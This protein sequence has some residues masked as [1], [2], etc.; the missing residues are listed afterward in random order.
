[1]AAKTSR[2]RDRPRV[3]DVVALLFEVPGKGLVRGQVATVVDEL[4]DETVLL[5]FSDEQ[6]RAYAT[7]ACPRSNVLTLH[8][9]T[10]A[11]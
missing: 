8:Y 4:D 2:R 1:M 9:V 11:A 10:N 3:L 7:L 6:G 5:E